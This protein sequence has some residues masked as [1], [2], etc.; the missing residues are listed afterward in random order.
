MRAGKR[1]TT[2][3]YMSML[4]MIAVLKNILSPYDP[5]DMF[6]K[7]IPFSL[8][9]WLEIHGSGETEEISKMKNA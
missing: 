8:H 4:K 1:T 7:E 9:P 5:Q 2:P 6:F 3:K